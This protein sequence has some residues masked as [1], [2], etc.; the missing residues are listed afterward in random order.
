MYYSLGGKRV[1]LCGVFI[2]NQTGKGDLKEKVRAR[3]A[4]L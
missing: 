4:G 2:A 1:I 3:F